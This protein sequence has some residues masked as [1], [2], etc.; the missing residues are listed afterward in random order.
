MSDFG[1]THLDAGLAFRTPALV[2]ALAFFGRHIRNFFGFFHV[3][4]P[5]ADL[6]LAPSLPGGGGVFGKCLCLPEAQ[7]L[8]ISVS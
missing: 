8:M 4:I 1:H 3:R 2:I 5:G 6:E 7:S